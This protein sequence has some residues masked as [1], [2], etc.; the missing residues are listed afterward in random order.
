MKFR[1]VGLGL[2]IRKLTAVFFI[3]FGLSMFAVAAQDQQID[4]NLAT[5][6]KLP[7]RFSFVVFGDNRAGDPACDAVYQKV[8]A[9]AMERKPDFVINT[10]DLV[11][12]PGNIQSLFWILCRNGLT[13]KV[14]RR[15]C[16]TLCDSLSPSFRLQ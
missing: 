14:L 5:L 7:S 13:E 6:E 11:N 12:T 8:V 4:K 15:H 2:R 10:G 3:V 16:H 9:A 1:I